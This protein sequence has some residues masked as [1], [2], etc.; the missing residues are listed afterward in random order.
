MSALKILLRDDRTSF[1]PG[2]SIEGVAGWQLDQA[3]GSAELR[4]F[5]FTRGKGTEDVHVVQRF[6]F[7]MPQ[8][9]EARRFG[10]RLPDMPYSF[11]GQIVSLIWAIELVLEPGEL[12]ARV[13]IVVSPTG[14]EILLH[15]H[16]RA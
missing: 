14:K 2:E 1:R 5:W 9:D 7:E 8:A 15:D 6:R 16:A 10:L 4:L 12:A 3:P 11:S 13:E